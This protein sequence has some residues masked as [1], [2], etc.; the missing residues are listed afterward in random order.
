MPSNLLSM[1]AAAC[2]AS[3]ELQSLAPQERT[4]RRPHIEGELEEDFRLKANYLAVSSSGWLRPAC[5][6][7]VETL[8]RY[9]NM[10]YVDPHEMWLWDDRLADLPFQEYSEMLLPFVGSDT[11]RAVFSKAADTAKQLA[12]LIHTTVNSAAMKENLMRPLKLQLIDKCNQWP[13]FNQTSR[14]L[15]N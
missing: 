13:I 4:K 7:D 1:P 15:T 2:E 5:Y 11:E 9:C 8:Q 3:G 12:A 10:E 6:S 14:Q